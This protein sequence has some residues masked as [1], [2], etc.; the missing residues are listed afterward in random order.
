MLIAMFSPIASPSC[1]FEVLRQHAERRGDDPAIDV[2]HQVV[3]LGRRQELGRRDQL[4]V[5]VAQPQQELGVGRRLVVPPRAVNGL[6]EQAEAMLGQRA[7]QAIDPFHLAVAQRHFVAV[8]AVDLDPVAAVVLRHVAGGV[9][10]GQHSGQGLGGI[11]R[12][13]RR[14]R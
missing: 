14:R 2:R 13:S 6:G 1:R 7:V 11:A 9:G 12:R 10:S 5:F 8:R 4:V 3:S